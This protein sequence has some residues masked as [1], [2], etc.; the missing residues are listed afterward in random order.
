MKLNIKIVGTEGDSVLVKY[1][2][3]FSAKSI[4]EYDAVAYQPKAMGYDNIEQFIEGIK[5]SLIL[6]VIDRDN[7]EKAKDKEID[8]SAWVGHEHESE[9]V[10]VGNPAPLASQ[11]LYDNPEV[12]L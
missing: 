10:P 7:I 1:A 11:V 4:D 9:H 6:H 8:L 5:P 2:S 12:T 3:E